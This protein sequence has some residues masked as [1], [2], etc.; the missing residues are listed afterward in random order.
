MLKKRPRPASVIITQVILLALGLLW[1]AMSLFNLFVILTAATGV[2][3]IA[4]SL[5]FATV[6]ALFAAVFLAGFWGLVKR[7]AYGRWI[8]V[9]GIAFI[10]I[11]SAIGNFVR[12]SGPLE[13]YEYKNATQLMG[14]VLASLVLYSLGF[15][16]VYRL[17]RGEAANRFFEQSD[18]TFREPP[19]PPTFETD[20]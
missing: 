18:P 5:V 2:T 8:G 13:Y 15:L 17:A 1:L 12:P 19:P 10:L 9:G 4:L 7:K 3:Q 20:E 14:G 6:I 11:S 16:L